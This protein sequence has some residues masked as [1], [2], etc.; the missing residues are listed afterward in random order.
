MF[1][2]TLQHCSSITVISCYSKASVA[3]KS[4]CVSFTQPVESNLLLPSEKC[5]SV[6]SNYQS[7]PPKNP[8]FTSGSRLVPKCATIR[9]TAVF[10]AFTKPGR[11]KGG[12]DKETVC[13]LSFSATSNS[14]FAMSV[15]SCKCL[16]SF[17]IFY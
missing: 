3:S 15:T 12:K 5:V 6:I 4:C 14:V 9:S 16:F 8:T 2:C 10:T 1:F 7:D 13:Q 17:V 11:V